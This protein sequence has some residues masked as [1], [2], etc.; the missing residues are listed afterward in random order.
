M[1][2]YIFYDELVEHDVTIIFKNILKIGEKFY[3]KQ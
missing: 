2:K 3:G 1:I